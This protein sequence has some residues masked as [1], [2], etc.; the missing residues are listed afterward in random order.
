MDVKKFPS[1]EFPGFPEI[2]MN[3]PFEGWESTEVHAAVIA[4]IKKTTG[5]F[6]SNILV[7]I[8]KVEESYSFRESKSELLE[9]IKEYNGLHVF[10]DSQHDINN[11]EWQV[12]EFAYINEQVGALG[13]ISAVSFIKNNNRKFM[14]SFTG[15][16]ALKK[17]KENII[18]S[19]MQE[20]LK[21]VTV[22]K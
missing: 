21:N 6:D 16:T 17:E 9:L 13:Q 15:T 10:S 5:K 20:I 12:I 8:Q 1:K 11:M 2:E 3:I 4:I 18:F 19:E 14:I 22:Y 7:N